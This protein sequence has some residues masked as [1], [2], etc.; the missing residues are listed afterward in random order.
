M[1]FEIRDSFIALFPRAII[2]IIRGQNVRPRTE[3]SV[4]L[5]QF[6]A[7]ALSTLRS[8]D[9]DNGQPRHDHFS[10]WQQAYKSFGVNPKKC[11]P[12]HEALA[13]RLARDP[14][15]RSINPIV[16]VYLSNQVEFLL[17][18]GGYD[19]ARLSG[20]LQLCRA[21]GGEPFEPLGGGE[22][23]VDPGEVIYQDGA[24]VLTRCWNYRDSETSKI[25]GETRDFVLMIESPSEEI[26]LTA[27]QLAAAALKAKYES[28][29]DG[30]FTSATVSCDGQPQTLNI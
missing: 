10:I 27:V 4:L 25:T 14:S 2:G 1:Q 12:T 17:P 21:A 23:R 5:T 9:E 6:R 13:R 22:E 28:A 11:R 26:P 7:Q 15:W 20:T 16:D 19:A 18:H 3:L 30:E 29:F 8:L 24:R